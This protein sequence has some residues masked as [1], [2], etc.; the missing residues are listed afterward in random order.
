MQQCGAVRLPAVAQIC[1]SFLES[2]V[3]GSPRVLGPVSHPQQQRGPV[4][5][6]WVLCSLRS[7]TRCP[8][9]MA[10]RR[11]GQIVLGVAVR[12][13]PGGVPVVMLVRTAVWAV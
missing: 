11:A 7:E 5:V 12:M 13:E 8:E 3:G 1:A 2:R 4:A 9:I 10:G 6:F